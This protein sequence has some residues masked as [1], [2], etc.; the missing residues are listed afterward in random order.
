MQAWSSAAEP[1]H[2]SP[3][4][5]IHSFL[6]RIRPIKGGTAQT[7]GSELAT[8]L[9]AQM[10]RGAG[11]AEPVFVMPSRFRSSRLNLGQVAWR[12]FW[13][14]MLA[15]HAGALRTAVLE[16]VSCAST[17]RRLAV[18][19]RLFI[20]SV[21][22][23]FFCL[24][25]VDA[26]WLRLRRGWRSTIYSLVVL[27]II[28]LGVVERATQT[29]LAYSPAHLGV[30]L[31]AGGTFGARSLSGL[32]PL[33]RRWQPVLARVR[34]LFALRFLHR[35]GLAVCAPPCNVTLQACV[36]PRAPPIPS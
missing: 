33:L 22:A 24:K 25:I 31:F 27:G 10:H 8:M 13:I 6:N 9:M 28:H 23:L 14:G 29:N 21:S 11:A 16:L 36:A 1:W 35:L 7:R 5:P 3:G 15:V 26:P 2:G 17:E 4:R 12:L 34:S 19:A 32:F 30:V 18:A 20:L